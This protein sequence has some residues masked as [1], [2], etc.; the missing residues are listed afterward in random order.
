MGGEEFKSCVSQ[1]QDLCEH[2]EPDEW[3]TLVLSSWASS[4]LEVYLRHLRH[5]ATAQ[6]AASDKGMLAVLRHYLATKASAHQTSSNMRQII[7]ACRLCEELELVQDFV[8]K[9]IWRMVQ[10]S[11]VPKIWEQ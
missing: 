10:G 5:M 11:K 6:Y 3:R 2:R 4:T 1:L 7:S 9:G 8:P